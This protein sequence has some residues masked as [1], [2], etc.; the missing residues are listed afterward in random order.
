[1]LEGC[2]GFLRLD[3]KVVAYEDWHGKPF[4]EMSDG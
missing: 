1:V 4:T 2:I 3:I